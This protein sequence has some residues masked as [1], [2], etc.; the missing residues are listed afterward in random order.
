MKLGRYNHNDLATPT[1]AS[2]TVRHRHAMALAPCHP[3]I[4]MTL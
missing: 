4:I 3:N 2:N 1:I